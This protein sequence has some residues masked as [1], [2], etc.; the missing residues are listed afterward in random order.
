PRGPPARVLR[1]G[2][3][4]PGAARPRRTALRPAA[5]AVAVAPRDARGLG[6]RPA[7]E[8]HVRIHD[9][10]TPRPPLRSAREPGRAHALRLPERG[11]ARAG[12]DLD[13][14]PHAVLGP[15]GRVHR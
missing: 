15:E 9:A 2:E 13:P 3:G 12:P 10:R 8:P 7:G 11:R 4:G 5:V 14:P 1:D 6:L